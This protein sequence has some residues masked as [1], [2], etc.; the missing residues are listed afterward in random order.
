[1]LVADVAAP[2]L[3]AIRERPDTG[4]ERHREYALTWY[5]FAA[6][7]VGLWIALG[8]RPKRP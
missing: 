3:T 4:I 6:T 1:V 7:A 8:F 5:A 2:G